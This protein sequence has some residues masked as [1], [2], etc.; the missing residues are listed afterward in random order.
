M[1]ERTI[2][3]PVNNKGG[4]GKTSFA[5]D[6]MTIV[7]R[8]YDTATVDFD[9]QGMAGT[10]LNDHSVGSRPLGHYDSLPSREVLLQEGTSFNFSDSMRTLS[11]EILPSVTQLAIFPTGMIY[12]NPARTVKL[13]ELVA[14]FPNAEVIGADLPPVVDP[15]M[16][17]DHTI[18]PLAKISG[19]TR[20]VPM[21]V[22]TPDQN[23]IQIGLEQYGQI[24]DYLLKLQPDVRYIN[25]IIVINKVPIETSPGG[26]WRLE[27]DV[28]HKI[29]KS[30]LID[31]REIAESYSLAGRDCPVFWLPMFKQVAD[32]SNSPRF[33]FY[34]G[35]QPEL[36][37]FP[38]LHRL[39]RSEG[40]MRD[41]RHNVEEVY[42]SQMISILEYLAGCI[43][44]AGRQFYR[45]STKIKDVSEVQAR[46]VEN[47]R[48][49]T[50][51][52]Y[53]RWERLPKDD[54][55]EQFN[56]GEV[57]VA[58]YG[59]KC[60]E[61]IYSISVLALP[62]DVMVDAVFSSWC[63]INPQLGRQVESA[64]REEMRR[65]LNTVPEGPQHNTRETW[66][67]G[68]GI[69]MDGEGD[70]AGWVM[71][72]GRDLSRGEYADENARFPFKESLNI[73]FRNLGNALNAQRK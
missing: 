34:F 26:I 42:P 39:V 65:D 69:R 29:G 53:Q 40:Y 72:Y 58:D 9:H 68:M 54:S 37:H 3:F 55:Y 4:V 47:M 12:N 71:K 57:E 30:G 48:E 49:G 11:I 5:V 16:I 28:A 21:I 67:H 1:M 32:A 60:G 22:V 64:S 45:T 44:H 63:E 24:Q 46:L 35:E 70:N 23:T 43:G 17:F 41:D 59:K 56:V 36:S 7:S 25:P 2:I 10:L 73:F 33:S 50:E 18:G 51:R 13:E 14:S 52:V 66:I 38:Q 8:S 19:A 31:G 15:G 6:L 20:F 61:I 27:N 62:I